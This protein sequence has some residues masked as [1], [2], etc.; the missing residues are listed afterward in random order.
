MNGST[1]LCAG[2]LLGHRL[3]VVFYIVSGG[4]PRAAAWG[5]LF[6]VPGLGNFLK[7]CNDLAQ[8]TFIKMC[9]ELHSFRGSDR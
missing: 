2:A 9:Q 4:N 7:A 1:L 8:E 6:I 3:A 5:L